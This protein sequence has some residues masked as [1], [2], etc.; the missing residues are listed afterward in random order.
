MYNVRAS[1]LPLVDESLIPSASML[2]LEI[3]VRIAACMAII[4]LGYF[5]VFKMWRKMASLALVLLLSPMVPSVQATGYYYAGVKQTFVAGYEIFGVSGVVRISDDHIC[6]GSIVC[7]Q[8]AVTDK[9]QWVACGIVSKYS[10]RQFYVEWLLNGNYGYEDYGS[11]SLNVDYLALIT[12]DESKV[13]CAILDENNNV[14]FQE[15][16]PR[17]TPADARCQTES[18]ETSNI[19]NVHYSALQY[20]AWKDNRYYFGF[21]NGELFPVSKYCDA[22][23]TL[24]MLAPCYDFLVSGGEGQPSSTIPRGGPGK[25]LLHA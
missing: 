25:S 17:F 8:L 2:C 10:T 24:T 4:V 16:F 3:L 5:A 14:C 9:S 11:A 19:V 21:W 15:S 1:G 13:T 22:P 20:F 7:Y 6:F 23:Y 12:F 18:H